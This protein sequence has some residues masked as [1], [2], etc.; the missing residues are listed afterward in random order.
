MKMITN[1]S[2]YE[3]PYGMMITKLAITNHVDLNGL[4]G[5]K[6]NTRANFDKKLLE[7]MSIKKV[8]EVWLKKDDDVSD[9]SAKPKWFKSR[10][11]RKNTPPSRKSQLLSTIKEAGIERSIEEEL[12]S[13]K[14]PKQAADLEFSDEEAKT[15]IPPKVSSPL[16]VLGN[17]SLEI[18]DKEDPDV[19]MKE[20][21]EHTSPFFSSPITKELIQECSKKWKS[22]SFPHL[23]VSFKRRSE[24]F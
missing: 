7:F 13:S 21:E 15:D 22:V 10:A 19:K 24:M 20:A 14:D 3:L 2:S 18:E 4:E 8:K 11:T 1:H 5:E 6:A 12:D 23:K 17:L 9:E 16:L